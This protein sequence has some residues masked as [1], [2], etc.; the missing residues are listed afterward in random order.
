MSSHVALPTAVS[1]VRVRTQDSASVDAFGRWRVSNNHILLSSQLTYADNPLVWDTQLTSGGTAVH[2]ADESA[3][4]MTVTGSSGSKVIRQTKRYWLYRAGQSHKIALTFSQGVQIANVR[5][6]VGYFDDD[7]GVFLQ[8]TESALAF[9]HRSS[10]TGSVVDTTANQSTWNLDRLDGSGGA[11]NPSG[12]TLDITKSQ[13]LHLDLQW[14]GVGRVRVGFDIGGSLINV[15]EF[16]F[17]NII[18]DVAYMSTGTLP[19]RYEI[20]ST[21]ASAGSTFLHMCSGVIREGGDEEEGYATCLRSSIVTPLTATT[22]ARSSVSVRLRS[23]HVRAFA[24]PLGIELLNLGSNRISVDLILNPILTGTLIWANIGQALQ[25]STTQLEYTTDS[26]HQIGCLAT[27]STNQN[28]DS[29]NIDVASVLGVASN[30]A[31]ASDILSMI[32]TADTG[33]QNLVSI[34][35]MLELF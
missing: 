20:E 7:N 6:R 35:K 27:E 21:D 12:I 34:L 5:K 16:D 15:H 31:G 30:I 4:T 22:T 11:N 18:A 9:V 23:T 26:G 10:V 33:T 32:V 28:K 3:V 13:Q 8:I 19:V 25:I 1:N 14:L 17:T 24:R 2:S 29:T